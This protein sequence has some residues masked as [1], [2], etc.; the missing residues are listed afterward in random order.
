M[1]DINALFCLDSLM[2]TLGVPSAYHDSA[3]ELVN[4]QHLTV[5]NHI[6][7]IPLHDAPCLNGEVNMVLN[8]KVLGVHKVFKGEEFLS[9]CDT[10]LSQ[11]SGAGLFVND[12]VAFLLQFVLSV[13]L[14]GK[15]GDFYAFKTLYKVVGDFVKVGG[16][17]GSARNN[18][19]CSCL[20]YED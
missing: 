16:L 8:C 14:G 17:V 11:S 6:V 4:N 3:R 13:F 1:S 19:R 20:V 15:L 12:V 9:L 7:N 5:L 2:Q 10:A 18:Q